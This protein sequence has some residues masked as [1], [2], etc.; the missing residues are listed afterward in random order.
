MNELKGE[1]WLRLLLLV[2]A[3][4]VE[5]FV[6]LLWLE[7]RVISGHKEIGV[8]TKNEKY[9]LKLNCARHNY[10]IVDLLDFWEGFISNPSLRL[11]IYGS[12]FHPDYSPT[13]LFNVYDLWQIRITDP[14][15]NS[16]LRFLLWN[17]SLIL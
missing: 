10:V 2:A 14:R 4:S 1:V 16:N 9:I 6:T 7:S 13:H 15:Q 3:V 8:R 11:N 12:W 17:S 5:K